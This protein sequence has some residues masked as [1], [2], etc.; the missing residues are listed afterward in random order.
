MPTA[1][2]ISID[3]NGINSGLAFS[4]SSTQHEET[5]SVLFSIL[6]YPIIHALG[7]PPWPDLTSPKPIR[8]HARTPGPGRPIAALHRTDSPLTAFLRVA[9]EE[10]Y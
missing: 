4:M 10:Y 8:A 3:Y 9:G 6:L 1:R 2:S 7:H 5:G